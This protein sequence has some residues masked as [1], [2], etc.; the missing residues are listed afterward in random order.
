MKSICSIC[1]IPLKRIIFTAYYKNK[2]YTFYR[3]INCDL[4]QIRPLINQNTNRYYSYSDS[5]ELIKTTNQQARLFHLLPFG[6]KIFRAYIDLCY[7]NRFRNILTLLS[8]G[9]IL[10]IGCGEGSFLEKFAGTKWHLTGIEI[11]K[12]LAKQARIK[13]KKANILIQ[14]VQHMKNPLKS[15][16]IITMWH[17]FEHLDDPKTIL[18][19]LY[20]QIAPDGYLVIEI[21]NGNSIYLKLFKS[22]WQSL[23]P[24]QHLYFWTRKSLAIALTQAGFRVIKIQYPGILSFCGSSSLAN[25]IRS[26]GFN[27][28]IAILVAFIF[29]PLTILINIFSFSYRDNIIVIAKQKK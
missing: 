9:R 28:H 20:K 19:S 3:C 24:P 8:H 10:D 23:L 18:K 27:S 26:F 15:F 2:K 22:H 17:V 6:E 5:V 16:E 29:F 4:I 21:P 7:T 12:N 25:L 13:I 11:N 14:P 1:S